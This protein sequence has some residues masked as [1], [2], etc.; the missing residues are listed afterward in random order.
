MA[1]ITICE[2]LKK[3]L[4]EEMDR[5]DKVFLMGEDIGA[6]GGP[7]QVTKGLIEKYGK[8]RVIETPIS[9]AGFTGIAVGAAM[10]GMRPIIEYMYS[11]FSIVAMDQIINQA[12]KMSLMTGGQAKVPL[13]IRHSTGICNHGAQH[14]QCLEA[15]FSHTPG[16]K[17]IAPATPYDA[18]GLLKSAI[19]DDNPV[20]VFEHKYLYGAKAVGGARKTVFDTLSKIGTDVPDEDYLV[21]IG[22]ADIK[23]EGTDVTIISTLLML[24]KSL[25]AADRLEEIGISAEVIDLRTLSPIDRETIIKSVK[26][27]G[28]AVTVMEDNYT[29]G[30]ASEIVS[31]VNDEAFDYLDNKVIR[32]CAEDCPVPFAPIAQE[33]ITPDEEK[34]F[35]SIKKIIKHQ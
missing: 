18:K 10:T 3:A 9:E 8:E 14:S 7:W 6:F 26:K 31:I 11:D 12:A 4:E 22:K 21:P 20:V 5:D 25:M 1:N 24:Y 23:R 32:I 30:L 15:Y 27:T 17:V 2:A 28:I 16:L 35:E 19:R 29:C 33:N 34:I 13:V